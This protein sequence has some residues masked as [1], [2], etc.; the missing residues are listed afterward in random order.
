MHA[1]AVDGTIIISLSNLQRSAGAAI[2][3][4][5]HMTTKHG[6]GFVSKYVFTE[7]DIP[8]RLQ[9][10]NW[11]AHCGEPFRLDLTMEV[12]QVT[13]WDH[14]LQ[15]GK[16]SD[17]DTA[18]LE[19]QNQLSIYL[20]QHYR[21]QYRSW[22]AFVK[23]HKSRVIEPLMAQKIVPFCRQNNLG[24]EVEYTIQWDILGALMENTYLSTNH[25]VVYPLHVDVS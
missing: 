23:G 2:G 20:A 6:Q 25:R 8:Q 16:T 21:D 3:H 1:Y 7:S 11:F 9:S 15:A 4:D 13:T 5:E 14:V 22:N 19:A 24:T 10:I 18:S 12:V 17:S